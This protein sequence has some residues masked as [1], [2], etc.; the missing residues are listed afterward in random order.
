MDLLLDCPRG[1]YSFSYCQI[2]ILAPDQFSRALQLTVQGRVCKVAVKW[3]NS[4]CSPAAV[5]GI[6]IRPTS[7]FTEE[8][9]P[10]C[11][12]LHLSTL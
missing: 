1:K 6:S 8:Q 3:V 11:I 10:G 5:P 12:P 9:L 4:L 7:E 2:H